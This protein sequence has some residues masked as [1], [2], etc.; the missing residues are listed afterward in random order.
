[1]PVN[2]KNIFYDPPWDIYIK[3]QP[4]WSHILN[5]TDPFKGIVLFNLVFWVISFFLFIFLFVK[6]K[7]CSLI[8][9]I[10]LLIL[11]L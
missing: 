9:F 7:Y 4:F 10:F 1:M 8:F 3:R 5:S 2:A 11:D 6:C